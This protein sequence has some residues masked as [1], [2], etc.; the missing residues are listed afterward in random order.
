MNPVKR[1]M[2]DIEANYWLNKYQHEIKRANRKAGNLNETSTDIGD[3]NINIAAEFSDPVTISEEPIITDDMGTSEDATPC[4]KGS[5]NEIFSNTQKPIEEP[6]VVTNENIGDD[7]ISASS[8]STFIPRVDDNTPK[9]DRMIDLSM[10]HE[11]NQVEHGGVV[12]GANTN[13][14]KSLRLAEKDLPPEERS[15]EGKIIDAVG[16]GAKQIIPTNTSM[17]QQEQYYQQYDIGHDP[18]YYAPPFV[19]YANP[20]QYQQDMNQQPYIPLDF[21]RFKCDFPKQEQPK[22]VKAEAEPVEGIDQIAEMVKGGTQVLG[23]EPKDAKVK[24][25]FINTERPKLSHDPERLPTCDNTQMIKNHWWLEGIERVATKNGCVV[26]FIEVP[27]LNNN[28]CGIVKV[29]TYTKDSNTG[30]F[31]FNRLKSFIID[32]EKNFYDK[33]TKIFFAGDPN[34]VVE[35]GCQGYSFIQ[36]NNSDGKNNDKR[37]DEEFL[38]LLFTAGSI[39]INPDKGLYTEGY[40]ILNKFVNLASAPTNKTNGKEDRTRLRERLFASVKIGIFDDARLYDPYCRFDFYDFDK[41]SKCFLLLNNSF[42]QKPIAILY[43]PDNATIKKGNSYDEVIAEYKETCSKNR[44][45]N[46]NNSN[47]GNKNN[48]G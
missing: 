41:D 26:Q 32:Y 38:N 9:G 5:E 36:S 27:N 20:I 44:N 2:I 31:S 24:P 25:S 47:N 43:A 34:Q 33:R 23:V 15:I 10:F 17:Y 28:P 22:P 14:A 18:N 35:Y 1:I 12:F 48:K 7:S 40:R 46:K 16:Y 19:D 8:S 42:S 3:E 37:W 30:N 11:K 13:A 6:V 29:N 39:G 4:N 45:R 21:G